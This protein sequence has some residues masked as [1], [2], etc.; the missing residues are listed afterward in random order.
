MIAFVLHH[1]R[2][3]PSTLES[4]N[5]ALSVFIALVLQIIIRLVTAMHRVG[6]KA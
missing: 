4:H 3:K 6:M 2:G 5:H 1:S